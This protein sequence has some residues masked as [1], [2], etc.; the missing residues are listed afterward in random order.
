MFL[1]TH[2]K[3]NSRLRVLTGPSSCPSVSCEQG[4]NHLRLLKYKR[5]ATN[6][7]IKGRFSIFDNDRPSDQSVTVERVHQVIP[8]I[9]T[10]R[11]GGGA[12]GGGERGGGGEGGEG[13]KIGE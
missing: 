10:L 2:R 7:C 8:T 3:Q 5:T 6:L 12:K 9:S 11:G 4:E 1:S 13:K